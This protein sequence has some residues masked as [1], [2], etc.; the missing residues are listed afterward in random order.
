MLVGVDD[1]VDEGAGEAV[2]ASGHVLGADG[3]TDLDGAGLNLGSNVLDSLEAGGAEAVD[4][5]GGGG[6]GEASGKAGGADVVGGF[7]VGDLFVGC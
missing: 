7:G 4:A 5:A 1:L 2:A 6:G 3:H